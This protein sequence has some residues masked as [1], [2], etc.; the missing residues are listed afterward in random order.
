[1]G[2]MGLISAPLSHLSPLSHLPL[3]TAIPTRLTTAL[4]DRYVLDRELGEGGMATVYLAQDVKHDRRVAIKVLKPELVA[5]IGAERFL[6]EIKLTA[7]LQHPHILP[8]HD[9][10]EADGLLFYVMPYVEG[11]SL[12]GRMDREK[13]IP[14]GEAVRIASEV[15][16]ALDYA[17]RNDVIHRDIKPENVL[18]HDGRAL[19]ADFGIALA[20]TEAGGSRLTETGISLG[21]PHY[22]SPEQAM[23]ER[24]LDARSDLYAL[25]AT[26]YEMLAGE[27]PFTGPTAQSIVAKVMTATAEPVTTYR[28]TVPPHVAQA[29]STAL[30][31]LP[32]DRYA[33]ADAFSK[34]LTQPST[35]VGAVG[36]ARRASRP[37]LV[38][39]VVGIAIVAL[40]AGWMLGQRATG[41]TSGAVPPSRLAVLAPK[42]GGSGGAVENRMLSVTRDGSAIVY[43]TEAEGVGNQVVWHPLDATGPTPVPGADGRYGPTVSPDGRWVVTTG[44]VGQRNLLRRV[45][46]TGGAQ[47][48]LRTGGVNFGGIPWATWDAD[49]GVWFSGRVTGGL[50]RVGAES[51]SAEVRFEALRSIV[52]SD[53]LDDGRTG[54]AVN[55]PMGTSSGAAV[56]LDLETGDTL[57]LIDVPLVEIRYTSGYL[58]Y[59]LPNNT[60]QA[61]AFDQARREVTGAPVTIATD[62]S[63]TGTGIAHFDVSANGTVVY[64]P[65]EP[66]T[67]VLVNRAGAVRDVTPGRQNYH[68]PMFSPSGRRVAVDFTSADGRDVWMLDLEQ[69]TLT[70]VTFTRDGHD[71]TWSLDGRFITYTSS[72]SGVFGVFRTRAEAGGGS[73]ERVMENAALGFTGYWL[74]DGSMLTVGNGLR[75]EMG[76]ESGL[77]IARV[78]PGEVDE[79]EPVVATPYQDEF[80]TVS[81]DGRWLAYVSDQSGERQV[82]L[83]PLDGEAD[84]IQVSVGGGSEPGWNPRGGEVFYRQTVDGR[85]VLMAAQIETTPRPRVSGRT[86]LFPVGD[87]V[88]SNPHRNYDVSPDGQSFIMVQRSAATRIMVIQQL[89][90]LIRASSGSAGG[91]SQ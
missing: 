87:M 19:V 81:P 65:E 48:A 77:D 89:P 45:P 24:D 37:G 57:P 13:Q 3:M 42:V 70:R 10:G 69:Q 6:A 58:V 9:S 5:V 2:Q 11:E 22:M 47:S 4:A 56:L 85:T 31:K 46:I 16:D 61:V 40:A 72:Q 50:V 41:D 53:I 8:L 49:G 33:T 26:L 21:T 73:P 62:V 44:E 35:A 12:R 74:R 38:M 63:L 52:L 23:G 71:P 28:S 27:P 68:S 90:E 17:H 18:L 67:L 15:A 60:L 20:V 7:N 75:D 86:E 76:I 32:A 82:Y 43:V 51:D 88:A 78:R 64:I 84:Q 29:V 59:A 36:E 80:P 55:M 1:M 39:G 91:V 14:V 54:L 83:R 34:A 25:G 66:R 30:Q 79:I